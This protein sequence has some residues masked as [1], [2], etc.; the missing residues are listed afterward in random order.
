MKV[1]W[2][3]TKAVIDGI[4]VRQRKD[5]PEEQYAVLQIESGT[6]GLKRNTIS[7]LC[8]V[9]ALWCRLRE[10]ATYSMAGAVTFGYGNTFLVADRAFD[11]LGVDVYDSPLENAEKQVNTNKLMNFLKQE[12]N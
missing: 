6:N 5:K 7:I 4:S 10:G 1:K 8:F 12:T 3:L 2:T 11:V 9:P